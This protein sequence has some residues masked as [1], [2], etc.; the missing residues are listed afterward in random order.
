MRDHSG[1]AAHAGE[2][3]AN[4]VGHTVCRLLDKLVASVASKT[5]HYGRLRLLK[6]PLASRTLHY[7]KLC[8][9]K[10]SVSAC[11]KQHRPCRDHSGDAAHAD[12]GEKRTG[13][14]DA[15]CRTARRGRPGWAQSGDAA[16]AGEGTVKIFS[17]PVYARRWTSCSP[18]WPRRRSTTGALSPQALCLL[19]PLRSWAFRRQQW[20]QWQRSRLRQ[21]APTRLGALR[22]R[23]ARRRGH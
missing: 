7:G 2:G 13:D 18:A 1:D 10:R 12:E 23:G 6:P 4:I 15:W 21:T 8:Y 22:G 11:I 16:H 9:L 3:T 14:L 17:H 20:Q 5:L 19:P